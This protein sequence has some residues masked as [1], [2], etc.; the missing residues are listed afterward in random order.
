MALVAFAAAKG[1][2]GV[3]SAVTALGAVW[4]RSALVAECDPSG[5]DLALRL[6]DESGRPL[7]PS[8]GLL[9]LAA[10][11]RRGLEP[12]DLRSHT[13]VAHGGLEVLVG[14][15][16]PE[17][18]LALGPIW[19]PLAAAC[20]SLDDADV[21]VDCGRLAGHSPA[22]P[23]VASAALLVFVA[24]PTVEGVAHLRERIAAMTPML[25]PSAP[26]GVPIAVV[27]IT[28]SRDTRS[29]RDVQDVLARANLDAAVVGRIAWDEPAAAMLSG[30][31]GG[32]LNR[33]LLIRSAR[34]VAGVLESRLP[35]PVAA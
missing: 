26:D 23:L 14:V 30:R 19:E 16:V 8:T 2:P 33:S 25:R 28:D 9:S 27:L 12:A 4:P 35:R 13:Q 17:Q 18:V 34:E 29:L 24:R 32:R 20:A 11:A 31:A 15:T 5:G 6:R 7:Q 10:T 3:T 22:L 21:L 1:S